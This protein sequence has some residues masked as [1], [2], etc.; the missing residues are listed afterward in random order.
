MK[1]DL[2]KEETA[3]KLKGSFFEFIKFFY[4]VLT[5]RNF[6]ISNPIGRESHQI[7]ICK[8]LTQAFR[9]EIDS[10]RLMINVSPGSGKSTFVSMWVAWSIAQYPDS[11]FLYISYSKDLSSK[12]TE[13]IKRII[14]LKHFKYLFDVEIMHDSR[15]KEFFKT[16]QGGIVAAAGSSGTITG[17]DAGLPGVDNR[18]SGSL[19]I[20]DPIKPSEASSDK[21]REGVIENYRETIQQRIRSETVPII[22]I[23]QRVHETD[24]CDYLLKG[25]DG[26]DWQ[27]VVLK[28]IDDAG[29][30]MYP[31][32]NS[33]EMLLNKEKYD[34]Y[35]FASQY[36]QDPLPAGGGLFKPEWF[37]ILE[38]EPKI[39]TTFI[40]ADTAET[41]KSWNDA[42]C[43]SFWGLYEI[44]SMA[45]KTGELGLHCLDCIELRIEP[46]DLEENFLDFYSNCSLH[47]KP[48]MMAA[49]EKK[50]T[51][52]TLL[53]VLR[54]QRGMQIREIQRTVASGSKTQRFLEIQPYIASNRIS[55]T[56][57]AQHAEMCIVHMSKITANNSHRH[58][59]VCYVR[60]TKIA[61]TD[62]DVNIEDITLAHKIITP[63]GIGSVTACGSTGFHKVIKNI[64]LEGT[65]NH[66]IFSKDKF[67]PIDTLTD[68]SG[69]SRLTLGELIKWKYLKLLFL[70]GQNI[71]LQERKDIILAVQKQ[72]LD[73]KVLK[74]F[75]QR[76]GN[77]IVA[78]RYPQLMLFTIRMA[79]VIITTLRIWSV[80]H[81]QN[82]LV[83]IFKKD[84]KKI[85][86]WFCHHWQKLVKLQKSGTLAMKEENGIQKMLTQAFS[87]NH[88]TY[89]QFAKSSLMD[90]SHQSI[91]PENVITPNMQEKHEKNVQKK[92]V[93][94]LTVEPYGVYYANE[95][96][97]SNCDTFADAIRIALIE[98]T[99][100]NLNIDKNED[101]RKL[102]LDG[103]NQGM[104]QKLKLGEVRYGRNR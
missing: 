18:F 36:Q 44:E 96:L 62:G 69:V 59:D 25:N 89:V 91:V 10:Q 33:L 41:D 57:Y 35:V 72:M 60:G 70:T 40:C 68:V 13:T 50:S 28:S 5:G 22:F 98:K 19:I 74:D 58:D 16:K 97:V 85:R 86:N 61:T 38:D 82:M 14:Q 20:D 21:I 6:L 17:L 95:I 79:I 23:G 4:P 12:H 34:P 42:T 67:I 47:H 64:G 65:P 100:Y 29:N 27:K 15:G 78:K 11:R 39:I 103:M 49:I 75:T 71:I 52:V 99:L 83:N 54:K 30:A 1:L 102:F 88:H 7:I 2:V 53:S 77:F 76:F 32:V 51:G 73:E 55:F 101:S 93:F 90:M 46:K 80:Y 37:V 84:F 63:F 43:F 45:R 3:S 92:E 31:E 48:P 66:P 24:L 9:L 104:R 87:K 94:N 26:Y 81:V 56:K 8:A